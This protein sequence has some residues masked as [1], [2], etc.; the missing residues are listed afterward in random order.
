MGKF[1]KRK[2]RTSKIQADFWKS[3][4]GIQGSA[5]TVCAERII[6]TKPKK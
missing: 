6:N 1:H 4:F 2:N 3:T 5:F